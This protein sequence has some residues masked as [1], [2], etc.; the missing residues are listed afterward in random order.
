MPLGPAHAARQGEEMTMP[1]E[2]H[3]PWRRR[4]SVQNEVISRQDLLDCGLRDHDIRRLVRRR[5][6]SVVHRGIYLTHTGHPT[7]EQRAWAAV[8]S[9]WPAALGGRSA[10]PQPPTDAPITVIVD[11][12]RTVS[13]PAGVRVK[14]L[15]NYDSEVG[16]HSYPPRQRPAYAALDAVSSL[17]EAEAYALLADLAQQRVVTTHGLREALRT[18]ARVRRRRL[19]TELVNDLETGACSVLEREYLN[20]VERAHGLP[21]PE[22]QVRETAAGQ[23]AVRDVLYRRFGLIIEL[24]GR[25]FHDNARGRDADST[26]DLRA[27]TDSD[28]RTIRITFGQATRDACATARAVAILLARGGWLGQARPCRECTNS[29]VPVTT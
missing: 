4:A 3:E 16:A 27:A 24:D 6:L 20:R 13:A 1:A 9:C 21:A 12:H 11:L 7:W 28:V 25:A 5:E 29:K 15:A 2:D 22:R 26:R 14:R 10:L 18:R 8:L 17:G 23:T 19:L